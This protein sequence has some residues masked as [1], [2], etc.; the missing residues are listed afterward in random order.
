M[1]QFLLAIII[2]GISFL[3]FCG[4]V[5]FYQ[6]I[7][8]NNYSY[9][10][11]YMENHRQ[12]LVTLLLGDSYMENSINPSLMGEGTFTLANS[13]RWIYY[14]DKLLEK[15]I[16]DM[17]KLKQVVFGM[18][19]NPPFSR[20]YHYSN[21]DNNEHEKYKYEKFMHI[22]Y[23]DNS[24]HWFGL[25]RGY[26]DYHTLKDNLLCD[27]L[28]Y[29][30]VDGQSSIWQTEHNIDPNVIYNE[31]ANEQIAEFTSYLKDMARLC[32]LHKVR[33]IVVTPPCHDSY[34]VNVRQEG[35]DILHGIIENVRSE[36]PVEYIDYLQDEDYRADSIYFNCSHL[37]SIG[38]DMFALRVKKD[39]GL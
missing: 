21:S 16:T 28:G 29:E 35:L 36:Y 10:Y 12:E 15:Y 9:K 38:A 26:I 24:N 14:D 27:S 13:S 19:Y 1:K 22:R 5:E 23:D 39:F 30:R 11:W 6:P 4:A 3:V 25:Y 17:P 31:Y 34:I 2:G 18:G 37:N 20:S 8:D 32:H 7:V 33:L